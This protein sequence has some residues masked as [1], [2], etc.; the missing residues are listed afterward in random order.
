MMLRRLLL[1]LLLANALLG[2]RQLGWLDGLLG[3]GAGM[4]EREP[5]RLEAQVA[6]EALQILTPAALARRTPPP[7]CL[8]AGPLSGAELVTAEAALRQLLPEG[9]WSQISRERPGS[10]MVYMGR[11]TSKATMERRADELRKREVAF[12][13][14]RDLP[15]YE[16]GFLFGRYTSEADANAARQRLLAQKVRFARVVRLEPPST[17]HV[18]RI[19]RAD[20]E[21]QQKAAALG[22]LVRGKPLRACG[23]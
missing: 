22:E 18:L 23:R 10:W 14:V 17:T 15:E 4:R 20:A 3:P 2:A 8:E 9:G 5:Q 19:P 1:L 7:V 6:P 13:E 21:L 16:P 11:Y 12:E